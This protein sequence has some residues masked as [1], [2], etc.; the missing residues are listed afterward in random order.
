MF[1]YKLPSQ[2]RSLLLLSL[3]A[4]ASMGLQSQAGSIARLFYDD[5]G[6]DG[7]S[8]QAL[9]DLAIFPDGPTYGEELD[10]YTLDPTAAEV[11][12]F[13]GKDNAGDNYGT[14][15][16]GF[17]Q[18]PMDGDYTF[19]VSSDDAS[20]LSLSSDENPAN[21]TM[22]AEETGCC[23]ALFSGDRLAQRSHTVTGLTKGSIHYIEVLQVE[24]GGGAYVQV[25]WTKPDG[26]QEIIPARH[27]MQYPENPYLARADVAAPTFNAASTNGGAGGLASVSVTEGQALMLD[28]DVYGRQ[29]IA[30]KWFIDNVEQEGEIL[31]Y[32]ATDNV[33]LSLNGSVVKV[34]ISNGSGTLSSETTLFV[35]QDTEAPSVVSAVPSGTPHGVVVTFSE[36]MDEASATNAANYSTSGGVTVE[37]V[38][39]ISSTQVVVDISTWTGDNFDLTVS[40]V[41]D[42]AQSPNSIPSTTLQISRFIQ[43]SLTYLFYDTGVHYNTF[44][45]NGR[46]QGQYPEGFAPFG[47]TGISSARLSGTIPYFENP[48]SGDINVAPAADVQNTFSQVVFGYIVPKVS[49][50]YHFYIATD[51]NSE[52]YLSTDDNP[53]NSRL[54]ASEADWTGV[55]NYTDDAD[56]HNWSTTLFPQGFQ[57]NAGEFYYVEAIMQEGGGGDNLAVAWETSGVAPAN[58]STPIPGDVLYTSFNTGELSIATQPADQAIEELRTA[59][60]SVVVEGSEALAIQY[61]W[62]RN[63][64]AINGATA[65]SYTTPAATIENSGEEFYVTAVNRDG[66]YEPVVSE[67]VTLTVDND[68]DAPQVVSIGGSPLMNQISIEF[69]ED[70]TVESATDL[71]NYSVA[72]AGGAALSVSAATL[73]ADERTV[74]LTTAEQ[75][76]ATNYIVTISGVVDQSLAANT[77]DGSADFWS[78]KLQPGGLTYLF[79]EGGGALGDFYPDPRGIGQYADG[80]SPFGGTGISAARLSGTIPYFENPHSGNINTAPAG[81]YQNNFGQV[82]LGYIVPEVTATYH[83]FIATD[84][85]SE[86]YLSSDD[87]PANSQLIASETDWTG[88]RNYTD[89]ADD[90]N[91]STTLFPE[92]FTLNAGEM[93]YVEA[94]MQEGGGGDNLAVAWTTDGTTPANGT[95]PI[96]GNFLWSNLPIDPNIV[97][98]GQFPADGSTLIPFTGGAIGVNITNGE[99]LTV[100]ADS[101]VMTLNGAAVTP[102]VDTAG[103]LVTISYTPGEGS[104]LS[105]N[106]TYNVELT[107]KDSSGTDFSWS[108][109]FTTHFLAAG[110]RFI[111][112]EDWNFESGQWIEGA[113]GGPTGLPYTGGAYADKVGVSGVDY[114]EVG[115]Q[116]DSNV[117]RT[118]D[119]P[120]SSIAEYNNGNNGNRGSFTVESNYKIGWTDEGDWYNYTRDFPEE[121]TTYEVYAHLA[122]GGDAPNGTL[123]L[124]TG[125]ATLPDQTLEELGAFSGAA[126]GD[127]GTALFYKMH[128]QGDP[129]TTATVTLSGVNTI[130]FTRG[131][132]AMD[133]DAL[134]FVPV[135]GGEEPP[136]ISASY[137][138]GVLTLTWDGTLQSADSAS[139]TFSD[140]AEAAGM[141]TLEVTPEGAMKFYRSVR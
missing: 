139:G 135:T 18:I 101:V 44:Y 118:T 97:F 79:Y 75:A 30:F 129:E 98:E 85:N 87:N 121:P 45:A 122:S 96:A 107:L 93:Y 58:G 25:G 84:D 22:I 73:S 3:G 43:G 131:A 89:D 5:P 128:A 109:T 61:Q 141:N 114:N 13:Q 115:G 66:T 74:T 55:R 88:V 24:G 111:E 15:T 71:G 91:W 95:A 100:D 83:F 33:P 36:P 68:V 76:Q 65:S 108:W 60:F 59:T 4:F 119:D 94:V 136:T 16:R 17:I 27:L 41:T 72:S 126:S 9:R 105:A 29:P 106:T 26:T 92:G 10:D 21:A 102:S 86:L 62:Y 53:A 120:N 140:V 64:V 116:G 132:G 77:L 90:S 14:L 69:D 12:G 117:Y 138:N 99:V 1:K 46:G 20:Q 78:Y 37:G 31:A 56:T 48:H 6:L 104:E 54:I 40:G 67:T 23:A 39:A 130:R 34:E 42:R 82:V 103:N 127:W 137:A 112:S 32:W 49:G 124:V 57:M 134:M 11:F 50:T 38:S 63:G 133:M 47:G 28:V 123:Q 80:Y 19:H 81:D 8:V 110:T 35:S 52:L 2:R 125:D 70:V 7:T 113:N 51:D